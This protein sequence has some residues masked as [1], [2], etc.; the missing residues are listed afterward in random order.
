MRNLFNEKRILEKETEEGSLYF[1]LPEDAFQKYVG[2]LGYLIRPG[3][4]H[5]PA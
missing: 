3:E 5:E 4:F 1:I 2:L